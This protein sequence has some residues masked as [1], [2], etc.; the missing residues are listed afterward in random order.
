M[1]HEDVPLAN[2]RPVQPVPSEVDETGMVTSGPLPTPPPSPLDALGG[3]PPPVKA[4]EANEHA[5][6][7]SPDFFAGFKPKYPEYEVLTPQTLQT[8]TLRS[9]K[10][11]E[12][13]AL[14]GSMVNRR[15]T[16]SLINRAIFDAIVQGPYKSYEHFLE[17]TT[18]R[19]RD[20]LLYGLY[21]VTYKDIH[22]Y[23]LDCPSCEKNYIIKVELGNIFKMDAWEGDTDEVLSQKYEVKLESVGD[24]IAL[25]KQPTLA[26]EE[27]MLG[28]MLF[29]SD[30][31]VELGI[32]M[33]IIDR[34]IGAPTSRNPMHIH[35]RPDVF[36]AYTEMLPYDRKAINRT[37]ME[38][39][40]RFGMDLSL[41]SHCN[42]C[43]HENETQLD[44]LKQFFRSIFE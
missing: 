39:F 15:K 27:G 37:Y 18:I 6:P 22:N 30:K 40:G 35:S 5:Q 17:T 9:L 38:K 7:T 31:N 2:D 4:Y 24:T 29:Q 11:Q 33:L 26:D 20:A 34:F 43:G 23:E 28:D 44:L 8:V 42:H 1:P 21:H 25:I 12:E 14:K 36:R 13:E 32:E 16:P 19:D 10:V 41:I 3:G